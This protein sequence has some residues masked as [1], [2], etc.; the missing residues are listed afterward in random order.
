MG[1]HKHGSNHASNSKTMTDGLTGAAPTS[2]TINHVASTGHPLL[3]SSIW[4]IPTKSQSF[5]LSQCRFG[6]KPTRSAT[7]KNSPVEL[8]TSYVAITKA[9]DGSLRNKITL[10]LGSFDTSRFGQKK[11]TRHSI[12]KSAYIATVLDDSFLIDHHA[13][14]PGSNAIGLGNKLLRI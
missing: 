4:K 1:E 9:Q 7:G 13:V 10:L 14:R 11:I 5:A 2:T 6:R 8:W 12:G 3:S